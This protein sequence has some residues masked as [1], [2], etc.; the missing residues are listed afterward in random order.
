MAKTHVLPSKIFSYNQECKQEAKEV[1][2][3]Q[4]A[5]RTIF[6]RLMVLL[7]DAVVDTIKVRAEWLTIYKTKEFPALRNAAMQVVSN[8]T[9]TAACTR[10]YRPYDPRRPPSPSSSKN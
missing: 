2:D 1:E 7:L 9:P 3:Y 4:D 6:A 8:T 5:C 10:P